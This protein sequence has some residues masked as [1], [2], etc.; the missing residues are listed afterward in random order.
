MM[1]QIRFCSY[2]GTELTEGIPVCPRCGRDNSV[3][4]LGS[5]RR[6]F[7]PSRQETEQD[8]HFA[9]DDWDELDDEFE[10][11]QDPPPKKRKKSAVKQTGAD[12]STKAG[13]RKRGGLFPVLLAAIP[14]VLLILIIPRIVKRLPDPSLNGYDFVPLQSGKTEQSEEKADQPENKEGQKE[15]IDPEPV[16][17]PEPA[18]KPE[19]LSWENEAVEQAVRE[20][21]GISAGE[22]TKEDIAEKISPESRI[23]IC[24]ARALKICPCSTGFLRLPVWICPGTGSAT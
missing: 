6:Q 1:D 15:E 4:M 21:A 8:D 2:C 7:S 23:W 12:K 3:P 19:G 14:V 24:Q 16:S 13:G 17:E 22:I 11:I 9:E 10:E 20:A 18:P 5:R